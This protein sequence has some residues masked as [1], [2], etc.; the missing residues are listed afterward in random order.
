MSLNWSWNE[1]WNR[2]PKDENGVLTEET[3]AINEILIWATVSLG[4]NEITDKNIGEWI[5]RSGMKA[6]CGYPIGHR[7]KDGN[8]FSFIPT[9]E[10]LAMRVGLT[11]NATALTRNQFK[12]KLIERVEQDADEE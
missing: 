4:L 11:T 8:R 1:A 7:N 9:R 6:Q 10:E 3:G 12:K 5:I 2:L